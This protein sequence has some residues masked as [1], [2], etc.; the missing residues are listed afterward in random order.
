MLHRNNRLL[1][2]LIATVIG[3]ALFAHRE[4][5]SSGILGSDSFPLIIGSRV[6]SWS[7]FAA[8]FTESLTDD[9]IEARFYRP[10]QNLSIAFDYW[11]SDLV[12]LGYQIQSLLAL[13]VSVLLV[14]LLA[15]RVL[16]SKPRIGPLIAAIYFGLHPALLNVVS[17]PCRR[18]E[19]LLVSFIAASLY[20]ARSP[21][22]SPRTRL[23]LASL[24]VVLA[25]LTKET[26]AIGVALLWIN[27]VLVSEHSQLTDKL[28]SATRKCVPLICALL[29]L[30][31]IRLSV[32]DG[33]GGYFIQ[34]MPVPFTFLRLRQYGYLLLNEVFAP[35]GSNL[36][37][38]ATTAAMIVSTLGLLF[39]SSKPT[40]RR[41]VGPAD[42]VLIGLFC[43]ALP[44]L[45]LGVARHMFP[46]YAPLPAAGVALVLAGL[47]Q[48][49]VELF[50]TR[51]TRLA[52]AG[53]ALSSSVLLTIFTSLRFTPLFCSYPQF[54][55]ATAL[56]N[57]ACEQTLAKIETAQPGDSVDLVIPT[58]FDGDSNAG[59][60]LKWMSI[61]SVIGVEAYAELN[62]S[63]LDFQAIDSRKLGQVSQA[64]GKVILVI[65]VVRGNSEGLSQG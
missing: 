51:K 55:Q 42:A 27:W 21:K 49:T 60:Q 35:G 63:Q 26:G 2:I 16:G 28:K 43:F 4:S 50:K 19:L 41:L 32:L 17:A 46:W 9:R 36:A 13:A 24:L 53:I 33:S 25:T 1:V 61:I 38:S 58:Y 47:A 15:Y 64:P 7:D 12:P 39:V 57:Q 56:M 65:E 22:G 31:A 37:T 18:S 10:I 20:V 40:F 23:I 62:F 48:A 11:S 5:L 44:V 6:Q 3:L 59:Y 52:L 14:F 34:G 8:T 45:T 54:A 29:I 30:F